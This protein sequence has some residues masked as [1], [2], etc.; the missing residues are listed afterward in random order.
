MFIGNGHVLICGYRA[1]RENEYVTGEVI[2]E[3]TMLKKSNKEI[4]QYYFEMFSRD[5]PLPIGTIEYGDK[6]DVILTGVRKIGI[7]ITNFF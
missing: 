4:E 6:P 7:E 2:S 1:C 3:E 5:Y